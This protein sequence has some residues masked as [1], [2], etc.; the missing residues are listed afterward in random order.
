MSA[1]GRGSP[2][3]DHD[4]Y[5]TPAWAVRRLLEAV[6]LPAG[7]WLEPT[8]GDGAII[9]AVRKVRRDVVW[10]A[11]E[12]RPECSATLL[13][14]TGNVW[15]S[16]FLSPRLSFYRPGR[17]NFD[18]AVLNPPFT[19]AQQVVEKCKAV[20]DYVA[21]L[22]RLNLL[23]GD[24]RAEWWRADM[25]DVYVLPNRPSFTDDGGTDA[26]AY[27]WLV[28]T[29]ERGRSSGALRVLPATALADRKR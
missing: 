24:D 1:T 11:C 21:A 9:R 25:P 29:P 17:R 12:L 10:T 2:R 5:P 23:E 19:L 4:N 7:S 14:L 15:T 20:S 18:A 27:C 6:A 8:A 3:I 28:W 26:T 22:V 16:D 13:G